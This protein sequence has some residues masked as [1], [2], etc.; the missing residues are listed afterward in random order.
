MD[1]AQTNSNSTTDTQPDD[2][3]QDPY[4]L[5]SSSC[6]ENMGEPCWVN[7]FICA[8]VLISNQTGSYRAVNL[9]G[10]S[11]HLIESW[12]SLVR[13]N[14]DDEGS[15]STIRVTGR[16]KSQHVSLP[17]LSDAIR[18]KFFSSLTRMSFEFTDRTSLPSIGP[19]PA[20]RDTDQYDTDGYIPRHTPY[21]PMQHD[22][23]FVARADASAN[24]Q[25]QIGAIEPSINRD[26]LFGGSAGFH[27]P[28]GSSSP[29]LN[30]RLDVPTGREQ[31]IT[32]SR[33]S[34]TDTFT[35]SSADA[36]TPSRT[37]TP[38]FDRAQLRHGHN[39]H[40]SS[41]VP[42][43]EMRSRSSTANTFTPSSTADAFTPSHFGY[44]PL[45]TG[46]ESDNS[47]DASNSF[48]SGDSNPVSQSDRHLGV[49]LSSQD[50][51]TLC[52]FAEKFGL[53][54]SLKKEQTNSLKRHVDY[55]VDGNM[56]S[57][58]SFI[59]IHGSLFQFMN[60]METQTMDREGIME[61]VAN[62]NQESKAT[63]VVTNNIRKMILQLSKQQ[64][65]NP[66]LTSYTTLTHHLMEIVKKDANKYECEA[67]LAKP[68]G[69]KAIRTAC[70]DA[71]KSVLQQLRMALI[72]SLWGTESGGKKKRV[73]DPLTLEVFTHMMMD[74][75]AEG[76]VGSSHGRDCQMRFAM[77]RVWLHD[78]GKERAL[79]STDVEDTPGD[80][81]ENEGSDDPTSSGQANQ[82]MPYKRRKTTVGG[83][84]AH[85]KAFWWLF[86]EELTKK[87]AAWGND[88]RKDEWKRYLADC[89]QRDWMLYGKGQ[90]GLLP[91][92][93]MELVRA[94]PP[95]PTPAQM[96]S[97][98]DNS[99]LGDDDP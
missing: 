51:D 61:L 22:P 19:R 93:N 10:P 77:I 9:M 38:F 55:N 15:A 88:L 7:T 64:V 65:I 75:W 95:L 14:S 4:T 33:S 70:N 85:K 79:A 46:T 54:N 44:T 98:A 94:A 69:G 52:R 63:V 50:K 60:T 17:A 89:V 20:R 18:H 57:V 90:Q 53:N 36:F 76:G 5:Q 97:A 1:D 41:G 34:A 72:S 66:A 35:S 74:K 47:V 3:A 92:L 29:S 8:M 42:P 40:D 71:A 26:A 67:L 16:V 21:T 6:K 31:I 27:K 56:G 32:H 25:D 37:S 87:I 30:H 68:L 28:T 24:Y 99:V 58:K 73:K 84:T 23:R 96:D 48:L 86:T 91:A 82:D 80:D 83:K 49:Q 11:I 43:L 78:L 12:N 13:L 62:A 59:T 81:N 39:E 2:A 45:T